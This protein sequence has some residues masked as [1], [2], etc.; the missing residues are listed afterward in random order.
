MSGIFSSLQSRLIATVGSGILLL[1]IVASI[2]VFQLK[3]HLNEY[4]ELISVTINHE[5]LRGKD[6]EKLKKYWGEFE[7]L[8]SDIQKQS[9]ELLEKL[10]DD[11]SHKLVSDFL[12]Q[13]QVAYQKYQAGL[14]AFNQSDFDPTIGDKAVTGIDRE[15]TRLLAEAAA[16]ISKRASTLEVK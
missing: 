14:Q 3:T 1:G 4:H 5:L 2:A 11:E 6:P 16:L 9:K 7:K 13:H 12:S 10:P 15:P 8:Q